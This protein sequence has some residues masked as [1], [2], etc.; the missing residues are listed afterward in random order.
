MGLEKLYVKGMDQV[1]IMDGLALLKNYF[2][3]KAHL[4]AIQSNPLA[5][6]SLILE[7]TLP[8]GF[9]ADGEL[10]KSYGYEDLYENGF[11]TCDHWKKFQQAQLQKEISDLERS[12]YEINNDPDFQ[13]VPSISLA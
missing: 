10:F 2:T 4:N 5:L 6:G 9:L 1:N 7:R 3:L 12:Y 13:E 11:L 8:H